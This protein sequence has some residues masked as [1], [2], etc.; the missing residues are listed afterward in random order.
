MRAVFET[1]FDI[2]YLIA[3]IT[4]GILMLKNARGRKAVTLFGSMALVLGCGDAFHLIPRALALC[5]TGLSAWTAPLGIGKL[6]TSITMTVFYM[7]LYYVWICLSQRENK[8]LTAS[9]WILA[10]LR[11]VLCLFPQN[12][13]TSANPPLLWGILRN[14]PFTI[15]GVIVMVLFYQIRQQQPVFKNLW[16]A[17]LISFACYLPVVLFSET[18]PAVGMLMIPKTIAYVWIVWM[19]WTY[20]KKERVK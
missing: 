1:T 18:I 6:V 14:I 20:C 16:L 15:L 4:L 11:I 8:A 19:G 3:V 17:V 9:V 5:T 12:A 10:A 7:L 2:V 13:W